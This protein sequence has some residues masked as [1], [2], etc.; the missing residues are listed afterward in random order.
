VL[1]AVRRLFCASCCADDDASSV[2]LGGD[3]QPLLS[4]ILEMDHVVCHVP[5]TWLG[6]ML[7]ESRRGHQATNVVA[8]PDGRVLAESVVDF[9]IF[10]TLCVSRAGT[11]PRVA[12]TSP[13]RPAVAFYQPDYWTPF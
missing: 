3:G 5:V 12:P 6:G 2:S 8:A 11:F 4:P 7:K 10:K 9:A 13:R 1:V